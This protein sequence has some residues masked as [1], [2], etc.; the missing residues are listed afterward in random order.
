MPSKASPKKQ[1]PEL[2]VKE[3]LIKSAFSLAQVQGWDMTTARDIAD[4]AEL[5][6]P[7]FYE[8]FDC[9]ED[10]LIAY[11]RRLD[12]QVLDAFSDFNPETPVRDLLF[13]ILMERF[14][15]A[16]ADKEAIRSIHASLKGDPVKAMAGLPYFTSS[17]IKMMEAAGIHP[18]GFKGSLRVIGLSGAVAWVTRTW[19]D[20]DSADLSKTMAALD[21]ALSK[22][23]N[24]A[25]RLSL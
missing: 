13:D 20:D 18:Y 21:N 6:L 23:E 10:I 4:A 11:S 14:D 24:L 22:I 15:L 5:T 19:L 2:S 12:Q 9:K 7:D 25:D 1:K 3:R 8:S 17:I 16:N